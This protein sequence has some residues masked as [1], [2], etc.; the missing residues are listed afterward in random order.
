MGIVE[1]SPAEQ[2]TNLE[3]RSLRANCK[4]FGEFPTFCATIKRRHVSYSLHLL[5]VCFFDEWRL[6]FI[7]LFLGERHGLLKLI[8][9]LIM[10]FS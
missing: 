9:P 7:D 6:L 1:P 3:S 4:R 8:K 2:L 5:G 10:P